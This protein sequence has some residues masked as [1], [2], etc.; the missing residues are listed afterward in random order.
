[1][2]TSSFLKVHL[3][4]IILMVDLH[5]SSPIKLRNYTF[6]FLCYCV[7]HD[8]HQDHDLQECTRNVKRSQSVCSEIYTIGNAIYRV[9]ELI[10]LQRLFWALNLIPLLYYCQPHGREILMSILVVHRTSLPTAIDTSHH[11]ERLAP[12]PTML[13]SGRAANKS[14]LS[15]KGRL[16]RK[17]I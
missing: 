13:N 4:Y 15:F 17:A 2:Y 14:I 3:N 11:S 6:S 8:Y 12:F 1:M 5:Y 10:T 9:K 7:P 16:I